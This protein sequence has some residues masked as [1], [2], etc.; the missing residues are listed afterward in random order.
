MEEGFLYKL[1]SS[2]NLQTCPDVEAVRGVAQVSP[3]D[4]PMAHICPARL[5]WT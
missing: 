5:A 2:L 3:G 1:M 4:H